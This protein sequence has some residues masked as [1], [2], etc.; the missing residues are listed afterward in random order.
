M[1]CGRS[2]PVLILNAEERSTLE[3]LIVGA[4]VSR[5]VK[6]RSRTILAC[7]E[8]K[9]N[10]AVASEVGLTNLTV[11]KWRSRFL[12]NRLKDFE[13]ERRGRPISAFVLSPDE[14]RILETWLRSPESSPALA[15]RAR[16]ILACAEAKSNKA[17]ARETGVSEESVGD[18][19]CRFLL[20]RLKG[21][22]PE[23]LG[24]PVAPLLLRPDE[25]RILE[26]WSRSP[27]SSLALA[28]RASV[29]LACAEGKSNTTVAQEIGMSAEAV[30]KLRRS[31]LAQRVNGLKHRRRRLSCEAECN[32]RVRWIAAARGE[33]EPV[34]AAQN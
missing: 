22:R 13:Q 5:A 24:R 34:M 31:F 16:V 17:V 30:G 2:A 7:A 32:R 27:E 3:R 9:T 15:R 8:G 10:M 29:I 4:R 21:L 11:G 6:Q 12:V 28:R 14:Q 20:R 19:R 23:R 18:W 26:T 33:R 1:T 25:Q